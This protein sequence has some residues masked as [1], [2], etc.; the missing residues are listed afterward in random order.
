V[1]VLGRERLRLGDTVGA[2]ELAPLY[3]RP[4]EAELRRRAAAIR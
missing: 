3:L 1:A 4:S 2:A